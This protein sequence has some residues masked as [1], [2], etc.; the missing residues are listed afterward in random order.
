M[1]P[2]S[3]TLHWQTSIERKQVLTLEAQTISIKMLLKYPL[4]S[5]WSGKLHQVNRTQRRFLSSLCILFSPIIIP[6]KHLRGCNPFGLLILLCGP[7]SS[8]WH[9]SSCV[10]YENN[11][12]CLNCLWLTS[13]CL[14]WFADTCCLWKPAA[15]RLLNP[16]CAASR[17]SSIPSPC[18]APKV[19]WSTD[20]NTNGR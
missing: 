10:S 15:T 17:W 1:K 12:L 3:K 14:I 13:L 6:C 19:W 4:V 8:A 20:N 7:V 9:D 16:Y 5:D 2:L 18:A 11:K